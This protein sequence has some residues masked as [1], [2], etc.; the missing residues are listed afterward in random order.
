MK[1][2]AI[3]LSMSLL[4]VACD[5]GFPKMNVNYD[6]LPHGKLKNILLKHFQ[7]SLKKKY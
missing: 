5:L 1:K 7:M 6:N 4:L 3:L 2:R